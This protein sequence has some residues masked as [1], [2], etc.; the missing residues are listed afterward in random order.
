M[1]DHL[2][3]QQDDFGE[4]LPYN[5][6][7]TPDGGVEADPKT[8]I[9]L[10]GQCL[11]KIHEQLQAARKRPAAVGFSAFW[12]SFLGVDDH[13]EP[14]TRILHLFDTRSADAVRQLESELDGAS[15]HQRTGCRL[16]TSYWPAKL[17]WLAKAE[18]D[19]FAKAKRWMSFGEFLFLK[20][21]GVPMMSVS[22]ASGTGLWNQR[23]NRYDEEMLTVLP[24]RRDQLWPAE[25]A[26]QPQSNLIEPYRSKW[27]SLDGIP[28][29]PAIGD[30]AC[31]N[32]GSGCSTP[33]DFALMVGTSGAMR[34]V[35]PK[36]PTAIPDGLWCYRVDRKRY[37]AGGAI[38][39]GGE[40]Y[41]WMRRNLSLPGEEEIERAL[42]EAKPGEHQLTVL[43]FFAGERSPYWRPD[44][45]GAI[46][47]L[48]L[49]T[50]PIDILQASL[51]A[52]SLTFAEIFQA[53]RDSFGCPKR[54]VGSGGALLH[55]RAWT[56]MMADAL[57]FPIT[58]SVEAEA[59]SRGAALLALERLGA[60]PDLSA[61][62]SGFGEERRSRPKFSAIY[63]DLLV[64]QHRL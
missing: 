30:G 4:Q 20:L 19:A 44:L 39:N 41:A 25:E 5:I 48:N 46:T 34:A 60:I 18:P 63:R 52:V 11:A 47:G 45:R 35:L 62:P 21:F 15:V 43:P 2:G 59:S 54:V 10:C 53:M 7:T 33:S 42:A 36:I 40:V 12:H 64:A 26:D 27:P 29:Y 38:S 61:V 24:V 23:E 3:T 9:D 50:R 17:L 56:Q 37:I 49:A 8:L 31:S 1:F 58:A 32:I 14:C 16:H 13:G 28:W 51:E 57:D 55:S 6:I 22:M